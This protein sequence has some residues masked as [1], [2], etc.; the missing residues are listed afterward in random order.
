MP[1]V[2]LTGASGFLGGHLIS[3]LLAEGTPVRA[4]S[5]TPRASGSSG[6]EWIVG[7]MKDPSVWEQ[8][9]VPDCTV[10]HL[11]YV[12]QPSI[13]DAVEMTRAM[14][15]GCAKAR[16]RRLIHCSTISVFGRTAGGSIN[17][18]TPCNPIDNYGQQKLAIERAF[19]NGVNDRFELAVLRPGA[20][21]GEGGQALQTLCNSL[22]HRSGWL[23][24]ARSS[25]FGQ[26]S[27]HL[28]PVENVVAALDFLYRVNRPVRGEVFIV[29]EDH[30][31][32]NTFRRVEQLLMKALQVPDYPTHPVALPKWVLQAILR[33]RGR[34]EI[35][36]YCTYVSTKLRKWG[37]VP[38]LELAPALQ[39]FGTRYR[40]S[41]SSRAST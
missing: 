6:I 22:V 39:A 7:D 2:V 36:P 20:V 19:L 13:S 29:A 23:N 24:F 38:S 3:L 34:S 40:D 30:D 14:V 33:L 21:F 26:R 15:T 37:F 16:I 32:S 18:S 4:L 11:A 10:V 41:L 12:P 5:R 17:E 1:P 27:M 35:D 25:L 28:V 9:L 8:L 31:P